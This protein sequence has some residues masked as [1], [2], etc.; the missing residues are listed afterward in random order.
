M[1]VLDLMD[2]IFFEGGSMDM[3]PILKM[4]S[5]S[6]K[7]EIFG[8]ARNDLYKTTRVM[9]INPEGH[10]GLLQTY[11]LYLG[12][13]DGSCRRVGNDK[14]AR[15]EAMAVYGSVMGDSNLLKLV[16]NRDIGKAATD[17]NNYIIKSKEQSKTINQ[18]GE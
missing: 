4:F 2:E 18:K 7:S 15:D 13:N 5:G 1:K 10:I 17:L 14:F 8:I 16:A 11:A 9:I 12:D 3:F 6:D